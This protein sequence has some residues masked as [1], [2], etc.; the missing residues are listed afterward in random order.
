[1]KGRLGAGSRASRGGDFQ[2]S[3]QLLLLQPALEQDPQFAWS[4]SHLG[5]I[6]GS[7][8]VPL[9]LPGV[10]PECRARST[11]RAS[12]SRYAMHP[13]KIIKLLFLLWFCL[14]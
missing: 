3:P 6:P 12:L 5:L 2:E 14:A 9:A 7:Q 10:I 8:K 13:P 4:G 11:P 1:M